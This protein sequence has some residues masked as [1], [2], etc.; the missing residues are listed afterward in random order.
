[1][2]LDGFAWTQFGMLQ[3]RVSH[4]A[5]ETYDGTIRVELSIDEQSARHVPMQHGMPG[6][7]EV[8]VESVAPWSLLVRS[9]VSR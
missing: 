4:V 9:V 6:E 2:R 1:M 5:S 8:E 7:V 3:G